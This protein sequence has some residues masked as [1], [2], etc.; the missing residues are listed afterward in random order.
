MIDERKQE[1]TQLL[2]KALSNLEIRQQDSIIRDLLVKSGRQR[3]DLADS[4]Q[5]INV[6]EYISMLQQDWT[7]HSTDLLS[8][9]ICY[10]LHIV[11]GSIKSK[12]LEFIRKEFSEF[13]C[14]DQIQS[15]SH[16]IQRGGTTFGSPLDHLLRQLLRIAIMLGEKKAVSD[17]DRCTKNPSGPFQYIALLEGIEVEKEIQLFESTRIV[18]I[19]ASTPALPHYLPPDYYVKSIDLLKKTLLVIDASISPIFCAPLPPPPP[20]TDNWSYAENEF[21]VEIAGENFSNVNVDNTY[22]MIEFY[23]YDFYDKFCQAL[24]LTCNSAVQTTVQWRFLEK[25]ELFNLD[26]LKVSVYSRSPYVNPI[27]A[28][29]VTGEAQIGEAKRLY[30]KMITLDANVA[31]RLQIPIDRWMKSKTSQAPEDKII[32]LGIALEALYLSD[33][34]GNSELSFQLRLRAAWHLGRDEAHRKELMK[35]FSKIYE[36]RSKVVHTGR[37]PKKTKK[38]PFTQQEIKEFTEKAQDLC[39]DSIM[40]IL[41]DGKFP[42]WNDLILGEESL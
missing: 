13:I 36:W 30:R 10:K 29:A 23:V 11:N 15:A 12:L 5:C 34:D 6:D 39:R 35:D 32:D 18:P 7:S 33:R 40:K 16:F 14:E 22:G 2:Q 26:P 38:T 37:L 25:H 9:L 4:Y 42:V 28:S 21:Q 8:P 17:F 1:L 41:E 3:R 24:S 19:P 20:G 31:G 27:R